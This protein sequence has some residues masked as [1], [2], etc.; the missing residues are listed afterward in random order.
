MK[1]E[2]VERRELTR[3]ERE[4]I[5]IVREFREVS[6]NIANEVQGGSRLSEEELTNG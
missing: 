3:E 5:Q 2:R 6:V 1:K 4:E